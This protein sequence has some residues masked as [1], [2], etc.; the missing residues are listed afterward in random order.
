MDQ[1]KQ[2]V[3]PDDHED[4]AQQGRGKDPF[5]PDEECQFPPAGSR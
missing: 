1:G 4:Q 2:E 5:L 3:E